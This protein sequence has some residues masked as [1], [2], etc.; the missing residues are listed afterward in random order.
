MGWIC[1]LCLKTDITPSTHACLPVLPARAAQQPPVGGRPR[2]LNEYDG[3]A[4]KL[5]NSPYLALVRTVEASILEKYDG[6]IENWKNHKVSEVTEWVA[7]QKKYMDADLGRLNYPQHLAIINEIWK[8]VIDFKPYNSPLYTMDDPGH[9]NLPSFVT[10]PHT[11]MFIRY[12]YCFRCDTRDPTAVLKTGFKPLYNVSP[13]LYAIGTILHLCTTC[14]GGVG[15]AV[16]WWRDNR[17]IASQT[18]VCVSRNLRGC[19]KYPEAE[20]IGPAF[21]Y[22]FR[23]PLARVGFDTEHEQVKQFEQAKY[24][25]KETGPWRPGEKSFP[26]IAPSDVIGWATIYKLGCKNWGSPKTGC[27]EYAIHDTLWNFTGGATSSD[28]EFLNS[29]LHALSHGHSGELVRV[30]Q[31]DDFVI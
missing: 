5:V 30:E 3:V 23:L 9:G 11:P 24:G 1:P 19:G 14:D 2:P 22:A 26:V 17:D 28:R 16:G 8:E 13:P 21:F 29:E 27:Y 20:Y 4:S 31:H 7:F 25:D 6:A 15:Q 18:S 10:M 12:G